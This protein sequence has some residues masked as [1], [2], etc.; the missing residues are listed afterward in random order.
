MRDGDPA[1]APAA[2]HHV[3]EQKTAEEEPCR[4]H[5]CRV[6]DG[7]A[8]CIVDG[9]QENLQRAG[10]LEGPSRS[11]TSSMSGESLESSS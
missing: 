10:T 6:I 3:S 8:D 5:E 7:E 2:T 1:S 11:R 9:H 4:R